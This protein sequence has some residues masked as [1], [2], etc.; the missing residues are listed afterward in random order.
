MHNGAKI[1]LKLHPAISPDKRLQKYF[2]TIVKWSCKVAVVYDG[3]RDSYTNVGIKKFICTSIF[4]I[5]RHRSKERNNIGNKIYLQRKPP[6]FL[7]V[8]LLKNTRGNSYWDNNLHR[9]KLLSFTWVQKTP[10]LFFMQLGVSVT[11]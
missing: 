2:E 5:L 4:T 7:Y 1:F 10:F 6:K 8:V 11:R 3:K 9:N